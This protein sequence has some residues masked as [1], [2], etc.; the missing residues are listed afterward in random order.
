LYFD[1]FVAGSLTRQ[2]EAHL[3]NVTKLELTTTDE[4]KEKYSSMVSTSSLLKSVNVKRTVEAKLTADEFSLANIALALMGS[5]GTLTQTSGTATTETL[6]TSAKLGRWYPLAKRNVSAVLITG[7]VEGTDF[8]VD[9][10]TGRV[11]LIPAGSIVE[12]SAV[13]VASYSY[14]TIDYKSIVGANSNVIEGYLRFI[15]DP[16]TG[17]LFE[18]E[19]WHVQV[20]PDGAFGLITE[21]YGNFSLTLKVLDD[22]ANHPTE[23]YYRLLART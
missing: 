10:V 15:G 12:E 1:R 19:I 11:Y 8:S 23:P 22:S 4:L 13:T 18:L 17:P 21:D 7:M 6:T 9:A 16:A 5:E 14:G 2:G 20:T 3:G